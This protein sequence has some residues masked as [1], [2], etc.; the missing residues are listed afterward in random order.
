[1]GKNEENHRAEGEKE[2]LQNFKNGGKDDHVKGLLFLSSP[3]IQKLVRKKLAEG[4]ASRCSKERGRAQQRGRE[5]VIESAKKKKGQGT[6]AHQIGG[7]CGRSFR[8]RG[9]PLG[10]AFSDKMEINL[11]RRGFRRKDVELRQERKQKKKTP[12]TQKKTRVRARGKS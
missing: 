5:A 6:K 11:E 7:G 10:A 2:D 1:M 9:K 12:K 3:T 4:K 8:R